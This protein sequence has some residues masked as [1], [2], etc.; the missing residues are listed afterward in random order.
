MSY[1]AADAQRAG[2]RMRAAYRAQPRCVEVRYG[3]LVDVGGE[4]GPY[5]LQRGHD[6]WRARRLYVGEALRE[7]RV[8]LRFERGDVE[9][10]QL[11]E[12]RDERRRQRTRGFDLVEQLQQ[13]VAPRRIARAG[14]RRNQRHRI[15]LRARDQLGA[16]RLRLEVREHRLLRIGERRHQPQI[17]GNRIAARGELAQARGARREHREP[18]RHADAGDCRGIERLDVGGFENSLSQVIDL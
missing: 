13:Y 12:H 16:R 17:A 10:A 18:L 14:Q 2:H 15:L 1:A 8:G 11:R 4:V 7:D 3:A 6:E 9:R 5:D